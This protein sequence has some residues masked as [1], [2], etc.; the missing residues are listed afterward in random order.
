M[1][2]LVLD[3]ISSV[4]LGVRRVFGQREYGDDSEIFCRW[5]DKLTICQESFKFRMSKY[6]VVWLL[7]VHELVQAFSRPT[8]SWQHHAQCGPVVDFY[9]PC[10]F[11]YVVVLL[12]FRRIVFYMFVYSLRRSCDCAGGLEQF[13]RSSHVWLCEWQGLCAFVLHDH[14]GPSMVHVVLGVLAG[15]A[16]A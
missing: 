7:N 3:G 12:L 10:M 1:F 16:V 2:V 11:Y 15:R 14:L 4:V 8:G 5:C 9:H 6:V 13:C